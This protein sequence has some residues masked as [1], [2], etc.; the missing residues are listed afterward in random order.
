MAGR[1]ST[2][3]PAPAPAT[4]SI[5]PKDKKNTAV[6][7][8]A[9]KKAEQDAAKKKKA[10]QDAGSFEFA[11]PKISLTIALSCARPCCAHE[12]ATCSSRFGL[13]IGLSC[14]QG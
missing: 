5:T 6:V 2:K 9:K 12:G 8:A 7:A 14:S 4:Q 13:S 10:E 11:Q 3:A 1:K